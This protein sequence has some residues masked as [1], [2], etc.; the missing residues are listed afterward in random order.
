MYKSNGK[1]NLLVLNKANSAAQYPGAT[2]YADGAVYTSDSTN[3]DATTV[4]PYTADTLPDPASL[5]AGAQ[6]SVDLYNKNLNRLIQSNGRHLTSS[7]R[8]LVPTGNDDSALV[9]EFV[10][11]MAASGEIAG[12]DGEFIIAQP[13]AWYS[14][15]LTDDG[16][17]KWGNKGIGLNVQGK[18]AGNTVLKVTGNSPITIQAATNK[19]IGARN[20]LTKVSGLSAL[21]YVGSSPI[22]A[23]TT[24]GSLFMCVPAQ[25]GDCFHTPK[26]SDL[27]LDG[28]DYPLTLSDCTLPELDTV[29]FHEFK[30]AIR[31]GYNIDLLKIRH[32]MFGS[33]QFGST[34]MNNSRAITSD[35]SD[36][37]HSFVS[38]NCVEIEQTWFMKHGD[39]YVQNDTA[40][41][42][43]TFNNCYFEDMYRYFRAKFTSTETRASVQFKGCHFSK[44]QSNEPTVTDPAVVGYGSRIQFDGDPAVTGGVRPILTIEN[45][46]ADLVP[47][48]NSWVSFNNRTGAI[49]WKNNQIAASSTLGHIRCIRSAQL[50]NRTFPEYGQGS[51]VL[52]NSLSAGLGI[53]VGQKVKTSIIGAVGG[54][55]N[56]NHLVA[57][58]YEVTLPDGDFTIATD[59]TQSLDT[60][61]EITVILKAPATVTGS[62]NV[63]FNAR[64]R[65]LVTLPFAAA[66]QG[67]VA[68]FKLT[69]YGVG[70]NYTL[71]SPAPVFY[72]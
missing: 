26:F 21:R 37:I 3:W 15:R 19:N 71:T 5:G 12:L 55:L 61:E 14:H 13:M 39:A 17:G 56:I 33:E 65:G 35:Y 1:E 4:K 46:T 50:Q 38:N 24:D 27:F 47:V 59:P 57:T 69:S 72:S 52:G 22:A 10:N 49:S 11:D 44:P 20:Y 64:L 68:I 30:D 67:Q 18:G 23:G 9:E 70:Y 2:I 29:W 53:V 40:N 31:L 51:Y 36:G 28:F 41:C 60:G 8:Y 42:L 34:Y 45:C 16:S 63:Y 66:Q 25:A 58:H 43:V 7:V 54:T 32:G 62:R 6:I 48:T